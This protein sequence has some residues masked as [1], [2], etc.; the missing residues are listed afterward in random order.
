MRHT[1]TPART[2]L[3][4]NVWALGL[5]SL[6]TDASSEMILPLLPAFVST[7]GGG[8]LWLGV[9][10]GTADAV[11]SLLKLVAGKLYD[12]SGR[13]KPLVLLGYGIS[14][15]TRPLVA[16]AAAPWHLVLVRS[17]DRIGK[18]LRSSPRDALLA[19][20]A[21]ASAHGRVFGFHRAMDHAGA[22]L[23][24][25]V[26]ATA[27]GYFALEAR[28]VFWLATL[29]AALAWGVALAG[30]RE[31]ATSAA[32]APRLGPPPAGLWRLLVPVGAATLSR[33]GEL[34]LLWRLGE[35]GAPAHL[36]PLAWMGLHLVKALASLGGGRL[37]DGSGARRMLLVAWGLFATSFVLL[38]V[39]ALPT[40]VLM[41][42]YG[43]AQGLSE[44]PERSLVAELA[45][46]RRG[47][48]FG[49][50]HT[51]V[52]LV[53]LPAG[54][55]VGAAWEAKGGATALWLAAAGTGVAAVLLAI[56]RPG[57]R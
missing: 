31:G 4:R 23:G 11:S 22:V 45:G 41:G 30:V 36:L 17:V 53:A 32:A 25:L 8:A 18:G 6:L 54:L 50:Y 48:A 42:L 55:W 39:E 52:G 24:A 1:H 19:A 3:T 56:L 38:A 10:E 2:W 37:V 9:L 16:L 20:S 34:F 14:S 13:A 49:W 47:T 5:V 26:A 46:D 43:L 21:S 7:L 51:L 28:T 33:I 44:A 27:V 15:A 40:L 57:A 35:E 29:P 12:R